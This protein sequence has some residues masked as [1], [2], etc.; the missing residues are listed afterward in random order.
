MGVRALR[1]QFRTLRLCLER[2]VG[3]KIPA[4]HPLTAW[5]LEHTALLLNASVRGEDGLTSWARVRGRPFG[6]RLVGFGE[7]VL[8][9]LPTKG[10]QHDEAGNMAS[11]MLPGIFIGYSRV[12]NTYRIAVSS[13][14]IVESRAIQRR[15]LE[16]RW[17]VEELKAVS[18]T[19][20]SIRNV[21]EPST[22]D[23]G[24]E[25]E[26]N[27]VP[28][29]STPIIPRRLKITMGTLRDFGYTDGCRQCDHIRAFGEVKGG[30]PH[31]ERCRTRIV[32]AMEETEKGIAKIKEVNE[33]LDRAL[34]RQVPAQAAVPLDRP[35]DPQYRGDTATSSS[36]T[37]GPS[38]IPPRTQGTT[39]T[40]AETSSGSSPACRRPSRPWV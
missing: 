5:L 16:D 27:D 2:R 23:F 30:V 31:G 9:K 28:T 4:R 38:V 13:G 19:P 33:R 25:T 29:E 18:A 14:E 3:R 36:S 32:K 11:R 7:Y 1:G 8:W 40:T 22:I 12:S 35:P 37:A 24:A 39:T 17:R 34:L 15:P 10:P 21:D 26:K 6:Q 20:W